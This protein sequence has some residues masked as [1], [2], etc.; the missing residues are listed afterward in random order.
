[1]ENAFDPEENVAGGVKYLK[2]CLTLFQQDLVLALAA[3]NAGPG[4]VEQHGG[5]PPYEETENYVA[6]IT[7]AYTGKAWTREEQKPK[8]ATPAPV[9][10]VAGLDWQVPEPSWKIDAPRVKVA[11]PRWKTKTPEPHQAYQ[12]RQHQ[13]TYVLKLHGLNS[14]T[15]DHPTR[16]TRL[17]PPVLPRGKTLNKFHF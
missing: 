8:V 12:P 5:V 15:T 7:A 11:A 14:D 6:T 3:Y 17:S 9:T 10:K 1:V 2:H 4:A 13:T 16:T